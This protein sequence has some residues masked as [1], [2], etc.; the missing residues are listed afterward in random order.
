MGLLETLAHLF[1]V[2]GIFYIVGRRDGWG[3]SL[4]TLYAGWWG[5]MVVGFLASPIPY[6]PVRVGTWVAIYG[7]MAATLVGY[8]IMTR[9]TGRPVAPGAIHRTPS[10]RSR[11][12]YMSLSRWLMGV[13]GLAFGMFA[14]YM[15]TVGD[16]FGPGTIFNE[17]PVLRTYVKR[18][19]PPT[20][21]HYFYLMELVPALCVL[22]WTAGTGYM[23]RLARA[24]VVGTGVAAAVSLIA[25]AARVNIGKGLLLAF[26]VWLAGRYVLPSWRTVLRHFIPIAVALLV[27]FLLLGASRSKTFEH[28]PISAAVPV[29]NEVLGPGLLAYNRMVAQIP[30]LDELLQDPTIED[31][32]GALIFHPVAQVVDVI[33]V[34]YDAPSHIGK[35]Y[36]VPYPH[37]VAT[38]LDVMYKDFGW[39]GI[40]AAS[41]VFGSALG[42][43][44][45]AYEKGPGGY[46][47][48]LVWSVL[49]LVVWASTTAAAF[50]K[51]SYWVQIGL[52]Y[53][54][55]RQLDAVGGGELSRKASAW[56]GRG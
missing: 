21:F 38:Q 25:T 39:P 55:G 51:L 4:G 8:S 31:S 34:R 49:I 2:A 26:V 56:A 41:F 9:R 47:R 1:L 18:T 33:S 32:Y 10:R 11:R 35:F 14:V 42:W 15:A 50:I 40:V 24:C 52:L 48:M 17:Q 46:A 19:G 6:D 44:Q 30:T 36:N 13:G 5:T 22:T 12:A 43:V 45:R 3:F 23:S 37:N 53:V 27:V 54:I 7:S 20:G 16:L 29:Q 28:S